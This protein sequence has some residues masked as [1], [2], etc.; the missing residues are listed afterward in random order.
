MRNTYQ[1]K[2]RKSRKFEVVGGREL[3]LRLPLPLAEGWEELQAETERLSGEAGLKILQAILE[4]EV[5]QKVG[6]PY[7]PDRPRGACAGAASR[8]TWCSAGR[9]WRWSGR[10]CA[11]GGAK[12]WNWRTTGGSSRTG[13]CSQR[14][15]SGWR[16][17]CRRAT[18]TALFAGNFP[19]AKTVPVPPCPFSNE[20]DIPRGL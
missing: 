6:P 5:R 16:A 19:L 14:W 3:V 17:G 11:R 10:G 1:S 7:R 2:P 15:S 20:R 8:A 9:R 12:K 18:I 4:E 13:V